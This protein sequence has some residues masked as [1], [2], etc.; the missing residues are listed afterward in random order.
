MVSLYPA[1]TS[2]SSMGRLRSRWASHWRTADGHRPS[3]GLRPA[4]SAKPAARLSS[5]MSGVHSSSATR[6]TALGV[7]MRVEP[8]W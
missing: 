5:A 8:C 7:I 2:P 4:A 6:S 1:A 3:G